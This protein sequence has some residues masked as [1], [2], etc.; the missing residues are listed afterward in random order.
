MSATNAETVII[1]RQT[2]THKGYEFA[3]WS[4]LDDP[5]PE[6]ST[7]RFAFQ[8]E[9]VTVDGLPDRAG[10]VRKARERIGKLPAKPVEAMPAMDALQTMQGQPPQQAEVALG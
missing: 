9:G 3:V 5:N 10:A 2:Q 7:M 1:Y 6:K 4:Y 8:V